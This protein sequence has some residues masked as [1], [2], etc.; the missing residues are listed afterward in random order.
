MFLEPQTNVVAHSAISRILVDM[1]DFNDW[2]DV[3]CKE[4]WPAST[5]CIEAM[6]NWPGSDAPAHTGFALSSGTGGSFFQEIGKDPER[7]FRFA[8]AMTL[9]QSTP[10]LNVSFLTDNLNWTDSTCPSSIVDVGGSTGSVSMDLLRKSP[11]IKDCVVEDLSDVVVGASAPA[12]FQERLSFKEYDFFTEQSVHGADVYLFR[13]ILHDWPD[14]KAIEI[15]QNQVPAMKPGARLILNE[16]CLPDPG[17]L[18]FYQEQF[19]R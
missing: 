8:N 19:L 9:I 15:L 4:M 16:I 11:M 2:I 18:T 12:E 7:A 10:P 1:P 3:V 14:A 17:V 13:S 5:R 6:V